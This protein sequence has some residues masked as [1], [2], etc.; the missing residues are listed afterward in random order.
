RDRALQ[1]QPA[2]AAFRMDAAGEGR[3]GAARSR[4]QALPRRRQARRCAHAGVRQLGR[5][6]HRQPVRDPG[7][8]LLLLPGEPMNRS[9]RRGGLGAALAAL[10]SSLQWRML[11]LWILATLVPTLLVA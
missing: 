11:L 10:K 7:A 3:V 6:P 9:S 5:H 8:D 4:G 1:R 2:V